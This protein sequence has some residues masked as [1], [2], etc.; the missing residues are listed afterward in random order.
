MAARPASATPGRSTSRSPR[1]SRTTTWWSRRSCPATATSRAGSIPLAR[2]SYL[3]SPPLVVAFALAGRVDIDLTREPLGIA[4]DGRPVFLA[5]VWPSSD[6]IRSVIG[7]AI[8][9]DL[10]RRDLCDGVRGRR[11]MAGAADPGRRPVRLGPELDLP[12]PAAVPR[13]APGV[14]GAGR[15]HRRG[16]RPGDARRLRHDRPHLAGRIDRRL[17]PGRAVAPG[18]RR[19]PARVQLLRGTSRPPRGHDARHLRQHPAAQ[20][21]GGREGGAVHHPPAVE[22]KR[23]SS[24]TPPCGTRAEGV[25]LL[26]LAGREYGSGSSRDWAAKG[27]ALLGI[28]AVLAESYERIH[29]SNLVGMGVLPLQ[30]RPGESAASLGLTGRETFSVAGLAGGLQPRRDADGPRPGRRRRGAVVRGRRP[31][32]RPDRGRLLPPRRDP[33]GRPA[34]TRRIGTSLTRR[35][36]GRGPD[37]RSPDRG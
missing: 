12:R 37:R 6:E 20:R 19:R 5:D 32:R 28:R 27:T 18:A 9:P 10:F 1:P 29:R 17:V 36:R 31:A 22:A 8:S 16:A 2:A 13:G 33:A 35:S 34:P 11:S 25:P 14:A 26:V 15:G 4:D 30:Y 24:T 3:A 21:A 23:R 7:T